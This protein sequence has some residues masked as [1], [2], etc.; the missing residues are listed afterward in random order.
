M[1]LTSTWA[2]MHVDT[3]IMKLS[4]VIDNFADEVRLHFIMI[5]RQFNVK[6]LFLKLDPKVHVITQYINWSYS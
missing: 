5:I 6:L 2:R 1:G 3:L 4:I